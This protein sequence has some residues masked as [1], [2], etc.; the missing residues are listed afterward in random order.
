MRLNAALEYEKLRDES[1]WNKIVL[2]KD[3][4]FY[5]AYEWSAWLIKTIVCTVEFQKAR[6]DSSFLMAQRFITKN[7]DY[8]MLGFPIESLSKYIPDYDDVKALEGDDIE[9]S[10]S[11]PPDEGRSSDSMNNAF[12]LWREEC[13][14]KEQNKGAGKNAL[15][16]VSQ[17]AILSRSGIFQ[18]AAQV[19]SYP[20]EKSTPAENIEFIS[21]LKQQIAQLL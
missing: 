5:H 6:Q 21:N 1:N 11:L 14:V 10:I 13:P 2:H 20:V 12:G 8:V 7:N 17:A 9:I 19:M 3:G 16:G 4:R 15:K 18:I